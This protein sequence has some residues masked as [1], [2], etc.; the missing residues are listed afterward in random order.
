MDSARNRVVYVTNDGVEWLV[1]DVPSGLVTPPTITIHQPLAG[2]VEFFYAE[3]Y[4]LAIPAEAAAQAQASA[5]SLCQQMDGPSSQQIRSGL[6]QNRQ[7]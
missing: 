6:P 3:C 7:A 5:A 2:P 4:G 1:L